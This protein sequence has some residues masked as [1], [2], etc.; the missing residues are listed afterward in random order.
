MG[1][2][3]SDSSFTSLEP[4]KWNNTGQEGTIF[5]DVIGKAGGYQKALAI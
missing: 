5:A 4:F 1:L 2:K 3:K